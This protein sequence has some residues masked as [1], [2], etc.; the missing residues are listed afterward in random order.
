MTLTSFVYGN[1]LCRC[2]VGRYRFGV[3][4]KSSFSASSFVTEKVVEILTYYSATRRK[5]RSEDIGGKMSHT[6]H[7]FSVVRMN[8][9]VM[10]NRRLDFQPPDGHLNDSLRY[11]LLFCVPA[12]RVRPCPSRERHAATL[13]R[14]FPIAVETAKSGRKYLLA[15]D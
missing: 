5:I 10:F 6:F 8:V 9:R 7:G 15:D 13:G 14:V 12:R 2:V 11:L 3:T 4:V 1:S